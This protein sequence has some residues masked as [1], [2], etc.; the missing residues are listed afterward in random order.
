[1]LPWCSSRG[2]CPPQQLC[3]APLP[4]LVHPWPAAAPCRALGLLWLPAG[5]PLTCFFWLPDKPPLPSAC[6][7]RCAGQGGAAPAPSTAPGPGCAGASG[8]FPPPAVQGAAR[9]AWHAA[10]V[11]CSLAPHP[12]PSPS[13]LP[14]RTH[15]AGAGRAEGAVRGAVGLRH[16]DLWRRR[17]GRRHARRCRPAR[18]RA[19]PHC[20]GRVHVRGALGACGPRPL[21]IPACP[22]PA[23]P[24]LSLLPP[25]PPK[26]TPAHPPLLLRPRSAPAHPPAAP[27]CSCCPPPARLAAGISCWDCPWSRC[28]RRPPRPS[29]SAARLAPAGPRAARKRPSTPRCSRCSAASQPVPRL[30]HPACFCWPR[31][32]GPPGVLASGRVPAA[33]LPSA[34][35]LTPAGGSGSPG[36]GQQQAPRPAEPRGAPVRQRAPAPGGCAG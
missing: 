32:A 23:S 12:S 35:L 31:G 2:G 26:A 15:P 4:G 30:H 33:H 20:S 14:P 34:P 1:M 11:P 3:P 13:L 29:T 19:R 7:G 27:P 24:T 17:Q 21:L 6:A 25:F 18:P 16:P 5:Q 8:S 9:A 22:A 36:R 10:C 28:R